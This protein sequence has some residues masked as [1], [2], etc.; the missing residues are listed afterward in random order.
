MITIQGDTHEGGGSVIRVACALSALTKKPVKINKIRE[1]REKKGL[2]EQH[3]Q[4]IKS[5]AKLCN[6]ETKGVELGS[7]ELEFIPNEITKKQLKVE[8]RTAGSACLALQSLMLPCLFLKHNMQIRIK[9]GATFNEKAPN[10][11]YFTD[12]LFFYLRNLG[13]NLDMDLI[14]HGF[15]PKGGADLI[16]RSKPLTKLNN[17][18]LDI[19]GELNKITGISLATSDLKK[20]KVAERQALS[21]EKI[22]GNNFDCP[23]NIGIRYV[24]SLSP[25][26]GIL[27]KAHYPDYILAGDALGA[28]GK[29]SEKVGEEAATNLLKQ[30]LS[31]ATVDEY[32]ADQLIPYLALTEESI[33]KVPKITD[34]LK[35]NI[36]IVEKFIDCKIKIKGKI[37]EIK[38]DTPRNS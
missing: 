22:L 11:F 26:S 7:R 18:Y 24:D 20:A 21:A 3:Y 10:I 29:Y 15:F 23:V 19:P 34:H 2:M 16:F 35:T 6:A 12:V 27:L 14:K 9:G 8:I 37:I 30:V 33:I 28:K 36:H 17:L 1:N 31:A 38:N 13:F 5:L 32:L 25:G 4:S